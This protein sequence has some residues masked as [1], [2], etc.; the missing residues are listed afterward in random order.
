MTFTKFNH[1][2]LILKILNN[3]YIEV[4]IPSFF[5]GLA[6]KYVK[7]FLRGYKRFRVL[8]ASITQYHHI[9]F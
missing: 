9:M 4:K 3:Q 6:G 2:I 8:Y 7:F 1:Y 5:V